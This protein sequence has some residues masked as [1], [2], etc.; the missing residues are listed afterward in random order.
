MAR[1]PE[2]EIREV[3]AH[4]ADTRARI[5]RGELGWQAMAQHLSEDAVFVDPAWGRYDGLPTILKF[6]E[7]SMTGLEDWTFPLEW[8]AVDGDHLLTGWQNRLPGQRADGTY[9]QAPGMSR[10]RYAGGGRFDYEQDLINMVHMIEVI[11]ESGWK[12]G[13]G[14]RNPPKQVVRLCAWEP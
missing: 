4:Y 7:D 11:R 5:D 3:Y 12:P 2:S 14:F 13:R 8:M 1:F 9:Y 6:F 10:M